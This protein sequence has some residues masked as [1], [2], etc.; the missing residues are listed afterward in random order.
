MTEHKK[1]NNIE[2]ELNSS[3]PHVDTNTLFAHFSSIFNFQSVLHY[4]VL[5]HT[6]MH[7]TALHCTAL[8]CTTLHCTA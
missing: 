3:Q 4:S 2:E 5:H 1:A 7:Y 6:A 8:H